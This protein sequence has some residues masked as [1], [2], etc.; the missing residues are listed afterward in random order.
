MCDSSMSIDSAGIALKVCHAGDVRRSRLSKLTVEDVSNVVCALF[1]EVSFG[2]GGCDI[3]YVDDDGD[4]CL[5]TPETFPDFA[6]LNANKTTARVELVPRK[7]PAAATPAAATAR[8]IAPTADAM[9]AAQTHS[10]NASSSGQGPTL[11]QQQDEQAAGGIGH[12]SYACTSES[13]M[14]FIENILRS[15][16]EAVSDMFLHARPM[17]MQHLPIL[18]KMVTRFA[19][20]QPDMA[21]D[22]LK[23][24]QNGLDAFPQM[25]ETRDVVSRLLQG[26]G[27]EDFGIVVEVL[28]S[29]LAQLPEEEQRDIVTIAFSEV[30]TQLARM[31]SAFNV[32]M[33]ASG[34]HHGV[35][36]DGCDKGPIVGPRYKCAVCDDYD[37]CGVCFSHKADVHPDHDFQCIATPAG[38]GWW[39][40]A[41]HK[42]QGLKGSWLS[43]KGFHKGHGKKGG[44]HRGL[45]WQDVDWTKASDSPTNE[46][47]TAGEGSSTSGGDSNNRA[48]RDES[49]GWCPWKS[50]FG[51]GFGKDFCKGA[52]HG[53][54]AAKG[55]GWGKGGGWQPWWTKWSGET[56]DCRHWGSWGSAEHQAAHAEA[57]A[58]ASSQAASAPPAASAEATAPCDDTSSGCENSDSSVTS[59]S[60][61]VGSFLVCS[62]NE[63]M[64]PSGCEG[65]D[66]SDK[67]AYKREM[68]MMKKAFE[69]AKKEY[70][71]QRRA[72]KQAWKQTKRTYKKE[73]MCMKK[74]EKRS[75]SNHEKERKLRRQGE[76]EMKVGQCTPEEAVCGDTVVPQRKDGDDEMGSNGNAAGVEVSEGNYTTGSHVHDPL[77]ALQ[78]MGFGDLEM[79]EQLLRQHNGNLEEVISNLLQ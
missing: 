67:K 51:K 20:K 8:N 58:A 16:G 75:R 6:S 46:I 40:W 77:R 11:Q 69:Q 27:D 49:A 35:V 76:K 3:K 7:Q 50:F 32:D 78:A 36:C 9:P 66:R 57:V 25:Q 38:R 1:P 64:T 42:G 60:S 45:W 34:I 18:R 14:V 17:I 19:K 30:A 13:L 29:N 28:L 22:V 55:K 21:A 24:L 61:G 12:D 5:L 65:D 62:D 54:G 47:G 52:R 44:H 53:K 10:S 43:R 41:P 37:L 23:S 15:N 48:A 4:L 31:F 79:N 72:L 26:E 59:K 63:V 2:Q 56:S 73:R 68:R 70:K 74:A 71:L 33:A 39:Q